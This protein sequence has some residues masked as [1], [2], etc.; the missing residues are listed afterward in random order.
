MNTSPTLAQVFAAADAGV[1]LGQPAPELSAVPLD[2]IVPSRWQPRQ[3]FDPAALLDLASDI[4]QHGVLTPPLVWQNEDLEY[5]LIAGERRIR[6]CYALLL[7]ARGCQ[8]GDLAKLVKD[9]A[10]GGFVRWRQPVA[11]YI[12]EGHTAEVRRLSTVWCRQIWG[13]PAQ[14]HELALVD[15]L[16]RADLSPLEEARALHDL[17]EEY[18]YTQRDLAGRLGKSQTWISQRLDLLGLA[19][20]VAAQVV[21]GELDPASARAIARLDPAV[22]P[23]AVAHLQQFDIKSKGA[24]NLVGRVLELSAPGAIA[25]TPTTPDHVL[26]QRVAGAVMDQLPDAAA[27]QAAALRYAGKNS[28][29]KVDVPS[30]GHQYRDL[31]AATGAAGADA[32]RYDVDLAQIW[33][34]QAARLGYTCATC[35]LNPHRQTV[36]ELT[37][38]AATHGDR[39]LT[40]TPTWPRCAPTATTCPAYSGPADELALPIPYV[41]SNY[42][43]TAAEQPHVRQ[44]NWSYRITDIAAWAAIVR[45][46]YQANDAAAA[47]HTD[48]RANGLTRALATYAAAQPS[49][50]PH[51]FWSQ[52]CSRCAFH[53]LDADDPA[54]SCQCQAHPPEWDD[55]ETNVA[56]LWQSGNAPPIGRC[57][58]FRL[59]APDR[60]LP[61]LPQ[62]IDLEPA[63]ILHL[64]SRVGNLD[65]GSAVGAA[66]LDV[67]R[68]KAWRRPTWNESEPVVRKLLPSLRPGQRL[69]L[70]LLWPDPFGWFTQAYR[71]EA[72]EAQAY[73]PALERTVPFTVL[74]SITHR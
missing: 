14:L 60:T 63:G 11:Q 72:L 4:A 45:H 1:P 6:A 28:H 55:Y 34:T 35:R 24:A 2:R 29:G 38:L 18:S 15:N 25:A 22:Q 7:A 21:A 37:A 13:R 61:N 62:S 65:S 32:T 57:R 53:K 40:T 67:P 8:D 30:A 48:A 39:N 54:Q 10:Q 44:T 59:K 36:A 66:W 19:P 51:H 58:L 23:A 20:A 69:A 41:P 27:R 70:I 68:S 74:Q 16:Q 17:L 5:E 73:V 9:L 3:Q 26:E 71:A 49:I 52:P 42:E 50:D 43:F 64:L 31:I 56:R 46:I 47:Q 12:A 33:L